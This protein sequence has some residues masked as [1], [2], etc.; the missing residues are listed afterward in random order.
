MDRISFDITLGTLH[1]TADPQTTDAALESLVCELSMTGAG[2]RCTLTFGTGPGPLP[3]PG[4]KVAVKLGTT[5]LQQA[6]FTGEILRVQSQG[7][8]ARVVAVDGLST[9]ARRGVEGV[10]E[11]VSVGEIA[12]T[13]IT[14]AGQSPG[15]LDPGPTLTRYTVHRQPCALD[16]L[17]RL[18]E[19]NGMDFFTDGDG[20]IHLQA[21]AAGKA[22]QSYAYAEAVLLLALQPAS[23]PHDGIDLW[24]EGAASTRGADKAHWLA[25]DLSPVNARVALSPSGKVSPGSSG[26]FPQRLQDGAVRTAEQVQQTARSRMEALAARNVYGSLV[27]A[28]SPEVRPG[29]RVEVTELPSSH[30]LFALASR[31]TPW[32]VRS[33]RHELSVR[34]GFITRMEF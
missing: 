22:S 28:G 3:E 5:L 27:V 23:P 24:G 9:L 21:P 33:V 13:L 16:Q 12:R 2:G 19:H 30:P 26:T 32:R 6:I 11:S 29:M 14:Q 8:V 1:L 31:T 18:A 17:R 7:T 20:K 15:T 25:R 4:Q 10:F 34:K